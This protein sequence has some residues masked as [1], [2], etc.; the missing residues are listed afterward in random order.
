MTDVTQGADAPDDTALFNDVTSTDT[1]E[2][3]E[4]PQLPEP[5]KV[6]EAKV[7]PKTEAKIEPKEEAAVPS[8]RFREET[9]ARRRAER[10]RDDFR[11]QLEA[12]RR[13]P[14][15]QQQEPPPADFYDNPKDFILAVTKS[16]Q[17]QARAEQ[18]A[19]FDARFEGLARDFAVQT[20]GSEKVDA[21]YKAL[22]N[23][24]TMRDPDAFQAFQRASASPNPFAFM[25]KWHQQQETHKLIGGDLDAYTERVIAEKMKDP[26]FQKRVMEAARGTAVATGNTVA[27]PVKPSVASSPSLGNVGAGGTDSQMVEPSEEQLFRA[28]TQAKRR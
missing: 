26:D 5:P 23:G 9:E 18:E 24:L 7:E 25:V 27:R 1:L 2:K 6:E 16:A 19:K 22:E 4:N 15:Q 21:A 20:Y 8:G 14:P 3:F 17:E 11:Q 10:E 13:P 28:A 12:L